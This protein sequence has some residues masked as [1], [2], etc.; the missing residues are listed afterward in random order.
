MDGAEVDIATNAGEFITWG[1]IRNGRRPTARRA[2]AQPGRHTRTEIW[3]STTHHRSTVYYN[4]NTTQRYHTLTVYYHYSTPKFPSHTVGVPPAGSFYR[5]K[6]L[7]QANHIHDGVTCY[8][9][10]KLPT[11]T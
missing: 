10:R 5:F 9:V 2:R 7:S 4:V 3:V 8:R 11:A 6:L 1:V